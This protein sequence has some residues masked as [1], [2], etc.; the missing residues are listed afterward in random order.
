VTDAPITQGDIERL[1]LAAHERAKRLCALASDLEY[2]ATHALHWPGAYLQAAAELRQL[3]G[4]V[5]EST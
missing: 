3:A 5:R 2:V 4:G 1:F